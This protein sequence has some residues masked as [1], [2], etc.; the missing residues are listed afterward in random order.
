MTDKELKKAGFSA[1][2]IEKITEVLTKEE[3]WAKAPYKNISGGFARAEVYDYDDEKIDVEL[4]WGV[5]SD[6]QNTRYA[7]NLTLDRET[8]EWVN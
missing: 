4:V 8:F 3:R 1:T 5:Q 6:C 2:E 7:E